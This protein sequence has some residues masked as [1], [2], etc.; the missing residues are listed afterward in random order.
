M[1]R[2]NVYIVLLLTDFIIGRWA[3]SF[4][5]IHKETDY[6]ISSLLRYGTLMSHSSTPEYL[7]NIQQ[8]GFDIGFGKR[9]TGTQEWEQWHHYPD[10]GV[11]LTVQNLNNPMFGT[12]FALFGYMNGTFCEVSKFQLQY[13]Y[14]LG[15]AFW[16]VTYDP[17]DNPRNTYIGSH[18]TAY[19]DL[20]LGIEYQLSKKIDLFLRVNFCHSSNGATKLPNTGVNI[21]GGNIGLKY[22]INERKKPIHTL[23]TI[24]LFTPLNSLYFYIAPGLRESKLNHL[25]YLK[26]DIQIGYQ[27]QFHPI[28]RFGAG[29]DFSFN[30]DISA[31][32]PPAEK[33]M[34]KCFRQSVFASF[35]VLYNR[36]V[37]HVS[38]GLYFNKSFGYYTPFYERAGVRFLL[39]KGKK[40]FIGVAIKAHGGSADFIE[41]TYGYQFFQWSDKKQNKIKL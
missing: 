19:V 23:D 34:L 7:K 14:G 15:I 18:L 2:Y 29:L 26:S 39:G 9:T 4:C 3:L 31:L 17:V 8:C 5:Q 41:W 10:Y 40:H 21:I 38:A 28:F 11:V 24:E 30:G 37:F 35:E 1:N 25:Y 12:N 32:F 33:N 6:Y 13:Q 22:H 36:F 27:R 16:P 20:A